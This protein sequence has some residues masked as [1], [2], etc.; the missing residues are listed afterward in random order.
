MV[1]WY[2]LVKI[3]TLAN[4]GYAAE[5]RGYVVGYGIIVALYPMVSDLKF[6]GVCILGRYNISLQ[7]NVCADIMLH[8]EMFPCGIEWVVDKITMFIFALYRG[9]E[10]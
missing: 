1:S 2:S 6:L 3:K 9:V 4:S 7:N 8:K 10:I 5:T